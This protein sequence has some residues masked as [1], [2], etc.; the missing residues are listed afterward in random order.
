MSGDFLQGFL[1]GTRKALH[2]SDRE[3]MTIS[4]P[5]VNAF[6]VGAV[7]ALFDRAVGFYASLVNINAYHQ[8]GV[9]AGKK[10]AGAF[11]TVLGNVRSALSK[12]GSP[13]TAEKI[14]AETG[15]DPEETYF[16]LCHLASNDSRVSQT[17]GSSPASD[18]FS[19]T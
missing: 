10:A 17:V 4:I 5:T 12:S 15:A 18:T 7:I 9:E 13:V 16:C 8:P 2:E 11:L 14:A 19:W 3:N 1:R 6:N